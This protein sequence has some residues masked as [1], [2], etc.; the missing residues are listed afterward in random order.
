METYNN[1]YLKEEDYM[2]WELHEIRNNI[3]KADLKIEE[4][5]VRGENIIKKYDLK[6]IKTFKEEK[7][8]NKRD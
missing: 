2:M 5:N 3:A 7:V 1:D 8:F 4:I 6:R